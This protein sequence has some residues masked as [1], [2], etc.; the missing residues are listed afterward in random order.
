MIKRSLIYK[1]YY[2]ILLIPV[3]IFSYRPIVA[4]SATLT[5][6]GTIIEPPSCVINNGQEIF[7]NFTNEVVTTRVD[8]GIYHQPVPYTLRCNIDN[9]RLFWRMKIVGEGKGAGIDHALRTSNDDLGIEITRNGSAIYLNTS[10]WLNPSVA[11]EL[12][13]TLKKRK[14]AILK[15]GA[16]TA[17]ATMVLEYE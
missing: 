5:V 4:E 8:S 6:I 3:L 13:A 11:P 9:D 2:L 16:F 12:Y 10:Y 17:T 1:W 7:V 14:G 15:A